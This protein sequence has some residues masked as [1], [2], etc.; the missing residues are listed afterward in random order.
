MG[1]VD[2]EGLEWLETQHHP[3]KQVADMGGRI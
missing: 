1:G 3:G 2:V